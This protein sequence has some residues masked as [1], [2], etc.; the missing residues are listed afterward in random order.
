MKRNVILI[1]IVGL[2]VLLV[3]ILGVQLKGVDLY[4]WKATGLRINE[5]NRVYVFHSPSGFHGDGQD[6]EIYRFTD[7][8]MS[9]IIAK[10]EGESKWQSYPMD[11]ITL[12]LLDKWKGYGEAFPEAVDQLE[13]AGYSTFTPVIE[14]GYYLLVDRYSHSEEVPILKRGA[15]NFSLYMID[16]D[17]KTLYLLEL[18]T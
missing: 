7:E 5:E 10:I 15:Y 9:W 13:R 16:T 2:V 3:I 1:T 4:T 17:R 8:E 12:T 18:D 11:D 14:N 6:Y